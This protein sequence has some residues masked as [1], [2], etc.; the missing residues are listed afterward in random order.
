MASGDETPLQPDTPN[1]S[2]PTPTSSG[3]RPRI[4]TGHMLLLTGTYL[5]FTGYLDYRIALKRGFDAHAA[6]KGSQLAPSS[7]DLGAM[8][9]SRAFTIATK[10]SVGSFLVGSA[11]LIYCSGCTTITDATRTYRLWA[12]ARRQRICTYLGL[13]AYDD[14]DDLGYFN[15]NNQMSREE[16]EYANTGFTR[17]DRSSPTNHDR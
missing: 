10:A 9:A 15:E 4:H 12:T 1:D 16:V 2:L 14:T 13:P 11:F 7:R 6:Q 8:V 5:G 17:D 3:Y